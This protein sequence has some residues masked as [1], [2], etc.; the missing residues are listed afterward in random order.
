MLHEDADADMKEVDEEKPGQGAREGDGDAHMPS[1]QGE[2]ADASAPKAKV[3]PIQMGEFLRKWACRRVLQVAKSDLGRVMW[4]MRQL[5]VGAP[6]GAEAPALFHQ[7]LYEAWAGGQLP[8]TLDRIK[9]EETNCFGSLEWPAIRKAAL[10]ALPRHF[11]ALCWKHEKAS[12]VM[13][14]GIPLLPKDRGAEQGDVDGPLECALTLGQ[15][16][17]GSHCGAPVAKGW[18]VG[19]GKHSD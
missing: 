6:G 2:A 14:P 7:L 17:G 1:V 16:A 12:S 15:V 19:L 3:R 9:I 11:L 10:E 5:G 4:T 18:E 13:Q 8:R